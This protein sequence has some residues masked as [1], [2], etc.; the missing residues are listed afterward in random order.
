MPI[1][2]TLSVIKKYSPAGILIL[3]SELLNNIMTLIIKGHLLFAVDN[4]RHH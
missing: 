1:F 4:V 3:K 2:F